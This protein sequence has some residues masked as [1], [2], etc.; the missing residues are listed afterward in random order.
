MVNNDMNSA[1]KI[2]IPV[3]GVGTR[4]RPHTYDMPKPL[5][6]VAG[7]PMLAHVLDPLL[8]LNPAEVA[9][10]VGHLGD[11]IVDYVKNNYSFK[12]AFIEQKDLLGLG[13]AINIALKELS[14]GP[15]LIVLGDTIARTDFR[16]FIEAGENVVGV[17]EVDDPRRF[18]IAVVDGDRVID[19]EEKPD[20]PRSDLA[21]IGLYYFADSTILRD[22]LSRLVVSGKTTKGEVQLTDAL[23]LMVT[24]GSDFRYSVVDEWLDCGKKETVLSTNRAL[25]EYEGDSP[26]VD[27]SVIIPPV[28]IDSTARVEKSIIGPYVSISGGARVSGSIISNS[29]VFPGAEIFAAVLED[30]LIGVGAVVKG[31]GQNL[32][33]NNSSEA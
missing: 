32:N 1:L 4:L 7:R 19:F 24:D 23:K 11:Q 27:G 30:S 26:E 13:F 28:R 16:A 21:I 14:D 9:F 6:P 25:L 8:D 10:V 5:I 22:Y 12:A 17:K 3:A 2:V 20:H 33:I 18:G 31:A 15:L 29:I